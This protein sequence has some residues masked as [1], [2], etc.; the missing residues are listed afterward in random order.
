MAGHRCGE[1]AHAEA[2]M[3]K[4]ASGSQP[5]IPIAA[6]SP[7]EAFNIYSARVCR[8][9]LVGRFAPPRRVATHFAGTSLMPPF[10]QKTSWSL[11]DRH[12]YKKE[13]CGKTL[14]SDTQILAEASKYNSLSP[15]NNR[16]PRGCAPLLL[17]CFFMAIWLSDHFSGIPIVTSIAKDSR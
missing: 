16:G 5:L 1:V 2:A 17:D 6:V 15:L 12:L 4:S 7:D 10:T 13:N 11:P 3:N 8:E 9:P 14:R